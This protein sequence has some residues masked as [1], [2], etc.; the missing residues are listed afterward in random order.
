ML[1]G[2]YFAEKNKVL[3]QDEYINSE[4][5]P[6]LLSGIRNTFRSYSR[7]VEMLKV[8]EPELFALIGTKTATVAKTT[9]PVT[10]PTTVAPE[11]V[12]PRTTRAYKSTVSVKPALAVKT[13]V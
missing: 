6:I 12:A 10:Q 13:E 7:M 5:K 8:N 4:D 1:I 2:M 3:T 9:R 11:L